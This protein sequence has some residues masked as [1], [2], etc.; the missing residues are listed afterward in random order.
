DDG[1]VAGGRA[2]RIGGRLPAPP[3]HDS[4]VSAAHLGGFPRPRDAPRRAAST[5]DDRPATRLAGPD[6]RRVPVE[7]AR[8]RRAARVAPPL[9]RRDVA[10]QHRRSR[11][12]P[13]GASRI[14]RPGLRRVGR[15]RTPVVR[16]PDALLDVD[17]AA[18]PIPRPRR[19]L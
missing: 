1:V 14:R 11:G 6:V 8:A 15:D 16:T 13:P 12:W 19:R 7:S 3:R 18:R 4:A 9:H 2:P 17:R 10:H 5:V